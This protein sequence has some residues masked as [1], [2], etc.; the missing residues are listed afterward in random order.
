MAKKAVKSKISKPKAEEP[1]P[2]RAVG[3][4]SS[5][6]PE[7]GPRIIEMAKDGVGPAGYASEFGVDKATLYKWAAAH[8]E[9]GI[10]LSRAKTEEQA[11]WEDVSRRGIFA[12]KFNA[13]IWKTTMAAKF[14]DDYNA[15]VQTEISGPK[16]GPVQIEASAIDPRK[17]TAEERAALKLVMQALKG[18]E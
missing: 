1:A 13:L 3:R 5:Y 18:G 11:W 12:D 9:F 15:P 10:A 6:K 7:Y 2:K 17:M 14:R 4:P 8:E 16:G